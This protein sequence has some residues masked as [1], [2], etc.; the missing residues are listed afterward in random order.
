MKT[1]LEQLTS[2]AAYHRDRRNIATHLI[3]VPMI[4]LSILILLARPAFEVAGVT[5]TPGL[6]VMLA[7]GLYYLRLDARLGLAMCAIIAGMAWIAAMLASL[8]AALWLGT[9]IGMF[10]IGWIIQFVGHHYEGRKPAFFD[11]IMGLLI[12]P[13]FVLA[14]V[15]YACGLRHE[16]KDAVEAD[17]GPVVLRG[18][19]GSAA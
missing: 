10:V 19:R 17:V 18:P 4:M 8:P 15:A 6:P 2:Y 14:E 7:A 12:G 9:G 16:L 5:V 3:G 1:A 11:D 13:F